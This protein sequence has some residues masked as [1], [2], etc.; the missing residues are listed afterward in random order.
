MIFQA[1][2]KLLSYLYDYKDKV[3]FGIALALLLVV[4]I[5]LLPFQSGDYKLFLGPWYNQINN[6]GGVSALSHQI[7][8]YSIP[9]QF[10]IAL[11]TYVPINNLYLYKGLSMVF[12]LLLAYFAVKIVNVVAPQVNSLFTFAIVLSLPTVIMNSAFWAQA[13]AIYGAFVVGAVYFLLI[14]KYPVS[15]FM[16]GLALAFKLQAIF[17]V[18][19]FLLVYFKERKFSICYFLI[20]IVTVWVCNLPGFIYGRNLLSPITVY[21]DQSKTYSSLNMNYPNLSGIFM[22]SFVKTRDTWMTPFLTLFCAIVLLF[23]FWYFCEY[24]GEKKVTDMKY[25]QLCIWTLLTCVMLLPA[26]HERYGYIA[27]VL[28]LTI[29]LVNRKSTIVFCGILLIAMMAYANYLFGVSYNMLTMSLIAVGMYLY[30]TFFIVFDF[31]EIVTK[32]GKLE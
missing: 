10:L 13:D 20:S 12:E 19:F 1:E 26:M 31:H 22:G 5:K 15:F 2:Q 32:P 6:E 8:N 29:A 17:I 16:L 23:G 28:L 11:F 4:R 21:L 9:Y 7:G 30:Y 25:L 18:P 14:K 3:A 24:Y 27:E